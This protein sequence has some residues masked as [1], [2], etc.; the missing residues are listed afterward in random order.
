MS[1]DQW[2]STISESQES[3]RA[4]DSDTLPAEQE[5]RPE[6]LFRAFSINPEQ[7]TIERL[8]QELIPG[9]VHKEDPTKVRDGNELGVY[10]S[11]NPRMVES[12]YA[13]G[14]EGV[15][16]VDTP[17]FGGS[18]GRENRIALPGCGI[19]LEIRAQGLDIRKPEITPVLQGVYNNGFEG[20]EW[21]A[22]T[23]GADQYTV[24][25]LLLS[26]WANDAETFTVTLDDD[27]DERLQTAIDTIKQEFERRRAVA[28]AFKTYL[29][30]L[31]EQ[32]R[33]N[34][35]KVRR[36]WEKRQ[37]ASETIHASDV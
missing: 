10:M 22:D 35:Y 9:G 27:S 31:S 19:V 14:G 18:R 13:K 21:I 1:I 6:K 20:D 17:V 37:K 29:E 7:L 4:P 15:S 23:V 25:K 8:R 34:E 36:G 32:D 12:A 30:S 33:A 3:F 28:E 16:Y 24:K 2:P 5:K 11:T 26:R